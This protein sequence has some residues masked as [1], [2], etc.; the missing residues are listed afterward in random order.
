MPFIYFH[1]REYLNAYLKGRL[2]GSVEFGLR[3]IKEGK[4]DVAT[5]ADVTRLP[6]NAIQALKASPDDFLDNAENYSEIFD[7]NGEMLCEWRDQAWVEGLRQYLKKF[8]ETR[9][10]SLPSWAKRKLCEADEEDLARW[11]R[12]GGQYNNLEALL[13]DCDMADQILMYDPPHWETKAFLKGIRRALRLQ[14]LEKLTEVPFWLDER[15]AE[16]TY[17]ELSKLTTRLLYAKTLYD[18]FPDVEVSPQKLDEV[19]HDKNYL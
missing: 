16:A 7:I 11:L 19:D 9:F 4:M 18:L 17:E 5:V 1:Q 3:L 13:L 10:G 14:M 12:E 6:I 8:C 15:M 2:E